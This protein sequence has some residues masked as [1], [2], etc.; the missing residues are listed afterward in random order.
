MHLL[1]LLCISYIIFSYYVFIYLHSYLFIY[2]FMDYSYYYF[3]YT[4]KYVYYTIP[5]LWGIPHMQILCGSNMTGTNCDLFTHKSSRSYL[6]HLVQCLRCVRR[7]SSATDC[8][9]LRMK[10]GQSAAPAISV[11]STPL[12]YATSRIAVSLKQVRTTAGSAGL[13]AISVCRKSCCT[14]F[15]STYSQVSL[16][17]V[18]EGAGNVFVRLADTRDV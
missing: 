16:S 1:S 11:C 9:V 15:S 14:R 2:L 5:I 17:T 7:E 10:R 3:Y 12:F 6:N 13:A 4:Q 18:R 8:N